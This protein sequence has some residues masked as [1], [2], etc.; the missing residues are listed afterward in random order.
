[1]LLTE[2]A[3]VGLRLRGQQVQATITAFTDEVRRRSAVGLGAVDSRGLLT[4][5]HDLPADL[6]VPLSSL[7]AHA[8]R[9]LRTAPPGAVDL[10]EGQG[11]AVRRLV[12]AARVELVLV[13][14]PRGIAP[15]EWDSAVRDASQFAPFCA[16]GVVVSHP[17]PI[18]GQHNPESAD[19]SDTDLLL[20]KAR[21][22]GVGVATQEAAG[23]R[24]LL[25][26]APYCPRRHSAA[27]WLF[28]EQAWRQLGRDWS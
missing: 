23:L 18:P 20:L 28:H 26:P 14:G 10:V 13:H 22:Y 11:I 2:Q 24:W 17:V 16:R 27:Q 15:R 21:F 3:L 1:M 6:P 9:T 25:E 8:L 7:D 4:V 5:L 12:P 19:A